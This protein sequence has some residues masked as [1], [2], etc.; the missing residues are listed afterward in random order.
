MALLG[1]QSPEKGISAK[2]DRQNR[3]TIKRHRTPVGLFEYTLENAGKHE[4]IMIPRHLYDRFR[5]SLCHIKDQL[6]VERLQSQE[7]DHKV[8]F[9]ELE[10]YRI[11]CSLQSEM[12]VSIQ[13]LMESGAVSV[14]KDAL[15]TLI[16]LLYHDDL[17]HPSDT[18]DGIVDYHRLF[19]FTFNEGSSSIT[20]GLVLRKSVLCETDNYTPS[21]SR[22][23]RAHKVFYPGEEAKDAGLKGI[24]PT[25]DG[26]SD[27]NKGLFK[28][29]LGHRDSDKDYSVDYESLFQSQSQAVE[30]L[31]DKASPARNNYKKSLN[32]FPLP[33]LASDVKRAKSKTYKVELSQ[34]DAKEFRERFLT[35]RSCELYLGFEIIDSIHKVNGR[36]KSF[37]FPLYYTKIS[38]EESGRVLH[39]TPPKQGDVY[40]NHIAL[41]NLVEQFS[42]VKGDE[43]LKRFLSHL[44]AQ[45]IEVGNKL[46]PMRIH[47]KLPFADDVFDQS[48]D[49]LIGKPGDGG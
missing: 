46:H 4:K 2:A 11:R 36:M 26:A 33:I 14:S 20:S 15:P 47:R 34:D 8:Y 32:T 16:N 6:D 7:I 41:I 27:T 39:V 3:F 21:L 18:F 17:D 37:R 5:S 44:L 38:V 19:Q 35:D 25:T 1:R 12:V 42:K 22:E 48:R 13:N 9:K 40:M 30:S 24:A 29:K 23:S 49:I 31:V 10:C 43:P 45:K 28:S